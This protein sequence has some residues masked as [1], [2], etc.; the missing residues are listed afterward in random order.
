MNFRY[1]VSATLVLSGLACHHDE[2]TPSP[3]NVDVIYEGGASDEALLALQAGAPLTTKSIKF[4]APAEGQA[5]TKGTPLRWGQPTAKRTLGDFFLGTAHAHGTAV[6]G[7]AYLLSFKNSAGTPILRVFTTQE[8]YLPSDAV[9]AKLAS[10]GTGLSAQ[11]TGAVFEENRLARDS[12]PYSSAA[13]SL[14]VAP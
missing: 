12:G 13:L 3:G 2:D 1:L 8:N 14:K 4:V 6:N 11:V 10:A 9:Y 7:A 5:L